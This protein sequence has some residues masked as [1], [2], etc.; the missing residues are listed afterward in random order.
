[1]P[2]GRQ[3]DQRA[4]TLIGGRV[5]AVVGIVMTQRGLELGDIGLCLG[6][7]GLVGR[8]PH[9]LYDNRRQQTHDQNRHHDFDAGESVLTVSA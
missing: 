3:R 4:K 9:A 2:V 7:L 5:V 6:A 1:M 8:A